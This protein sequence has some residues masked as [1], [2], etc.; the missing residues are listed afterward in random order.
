MQRTLQAGLRG[1]SES[2]EG[3]DVTSPETA[4]ERE[5]EG[6]YEDTSARTVAVFNH[7][8]SICSFWWMVLCPVFE[9]VCVFVWR[10]N[11]SEEDRV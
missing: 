5:R 2:L 9:C 8:N 7:S 10:A 1:A 4:S 11:T 3:S 6:E